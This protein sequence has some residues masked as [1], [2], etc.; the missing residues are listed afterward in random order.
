MNKCSIFGHKRYRPLPPFGDKASG[1]WKL[2]PIYDHCVKCNK[3]VG[4]WLWVLK[5]WMYFKK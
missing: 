1:D 5:H 3:I 4:V 2:I